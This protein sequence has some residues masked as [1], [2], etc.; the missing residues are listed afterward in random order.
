MSKAEFE[1]VYHTYFT[2]LCLYAEKIIGIRQSAE[3]LVEDT[4]AKLWERRD[5]AKIINIYAYLNTIIRNACLDYLKDKQRKLQT[6]N[7]I[8]YTLLNY[9]DA[10]LELIRTEVFRQMELAIE[11]L[12]ETFRRVIKMAY[13][14]RMQSKAIAENLGV[15]LSTVEKHKAKGLVMLRT[16]LGKGTFGLLFMVIH[17]ASR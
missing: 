17:E 10:D 3:D 6:H 15:S 1:Q 14:D 16:I 8:E 13:M 4:F 5:Q 11:D 2:A 7:S 9:P 12:P